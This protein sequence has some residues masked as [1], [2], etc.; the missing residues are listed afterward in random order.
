M[1]KPPE[2]KTAKLFSERYDGLWR[3][4]L[5]L[6]AIGCCLLLLIPP[7][8]AL[9]KIAREGG[10]P[11][12]DGQENGD[13]AGERRVLLTAAPSE[14]EMFV[15][16]RDENNLAVTGETFFITLTSPDGDSAD[17]VTW[18]DGSC[19]IVELSPGEYTVSM[20][21]TEGYVSPEPI[22]CTV[23]DKTQPAADGWKRESGHIFYYNAE[24]RKA[25]GLKNIDGK[26]YYF[27]F[28]GEKAASLGIDVSCFNGHINWKAVRAQGIDFA[29]VRAGG[30]GWM[31]GT[32]YQDTFLQENLLEA[33]KA[34]LKT[35]VYFYSTAVNT[36]EARQEAGFVLEK[37][38]GVH[39]DYPVFIDMELSGSYPR[40][41][42]DTLTTA[43]RVDIAHA[44]CRTVIGS[45]Y[46]AGI[47]ASE[48][49]MNNFMDY[50]AL[51][52]YSCW[53]ANYT[54]NNALPAFSGRYAL[55]QFTDAGQL[56]GI[57]GTVD[58]NVIF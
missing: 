23:Q 48:Y 53:L 42:A 16:V 34:G 46:S 18:T 24:G 8:S 11:A 12:H 33:G 55:W 9:T 25:V 1:H 39:L 17:Y 37:L 10:L 22:R 7:L 50:R 36:A 6:L 19:Y 41:R 45:G 14:R 54:G 38:R 40:G 20:R 4:V 58:M 29:I 51:S 35:G 15:T 56:N 2:K 57:S 26:L 3:I 28:R 31:S 21:D 27:N 47:Y 49:Y 43:Q 5:P 30:R 13:Y 52:Q 32:V 44:F